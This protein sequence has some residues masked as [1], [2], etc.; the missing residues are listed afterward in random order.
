MGQDGAP[1]RTLTSYTRGI[2]S[3]VY[4][5]SGEQIA[6][7]GFDG[8]ERRAAHLWE[9]EKD[10]EGDKDKL[11]SNPRHEALDAT[12]TLIDG[13]QGLSEVNRALMKQRG[14]N[15]EVVLSDLA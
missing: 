12:D 14:A 8:F 15:D 3:V 11:V 9:V 7:G 10:Q 6:F 5:P 2:N 1:R 13:V 4:S